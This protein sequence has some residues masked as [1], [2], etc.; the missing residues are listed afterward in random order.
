MLTP[1]SSASDPTS[2]VSGGSRKANSSQNTTLEV[3]PYT[4]LNTS[5]KQLSGSMETLTQSLEPFLE[6]FQRS[7]EIHLAALSMYVFLGPIL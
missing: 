4:V 5:L 3:D 1:K 2:S 6:H 7:Q